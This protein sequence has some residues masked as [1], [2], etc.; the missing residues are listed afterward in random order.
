MKVVFLIAS[1]APFTRALQEL[2]GLITRRVQLE[3]S[4]E[5]ITPDAPLLEDR[6]GKE[7]V[8][9]D[10][11]F[12][13]TV[14]QMGGTLRWFIR[15]GAFKLKLSNHGWLATY[16]GSRRSLNAPNSRHCRVLCYFRRL[17]L[18][19]GGAPMLYATNKH[20]SW[21]WHE[22]SRHRQANA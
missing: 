22:D 10:A 16:E 9:T 8:L 4:G 5:G 18:D 3:R 12:I 2:L 11:D 15:F 14:L 19:F 17:L 6:N 21:A 20:K 13:F 7:C 1:S